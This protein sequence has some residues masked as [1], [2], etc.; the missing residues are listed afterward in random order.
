MA[1]L[2]DGREVVVKIK[3]PAI[4]NI[5]KNDTDNIVDVVN[6]L[7]RV[8]IDTGATSGQV[9]HESIDYLLSESDYEKE[10]HNATHA[11]SV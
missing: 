5:M 8:G 1:R 3:R 4:Y 11:K 9:L 6:F 10:I 7:E 2:L